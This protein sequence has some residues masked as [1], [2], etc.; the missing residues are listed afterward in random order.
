MGNDEKKTINGFHS[1][2]DE[3]HYTLD[4][5][6]TLKELGN[7]MK[8]G[9]EA[10]EK[11]FEDAKDSGTG[12][13]VRL[14]SKGDNFFVVGEASG[15]YVTAERPGKTRQEIKE[16]LQL[17]P[18]NEADKIKT[19]EVARPF[20]AME[21]RVKAQ[22]EWAEKAGYKAKDGIGQIYVTNHNEKGAIKDGK[23]EVK[24]EEMIFD[25]E[26]RENELVEKRRDIGNKID[27]GNERIR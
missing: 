9:G 26:E 18:G 3:K 24:K 2:T 22:P 25:L 12:E 27:D 8:Q 4:Q 17:P 1:G 10:F 20:V 15:N 5:E 11:R 7:Y 6:M 23:L 19:V 14:V 13:K 21:S 16:N